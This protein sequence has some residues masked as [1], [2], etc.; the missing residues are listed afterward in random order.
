M[1]NKGKHK[2]LPISNKIN[3]LSQVAAHIGTC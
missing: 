3:I 2:S 1:D